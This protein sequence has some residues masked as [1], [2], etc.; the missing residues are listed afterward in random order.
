MAVLYVGLTIGLYLLFRELYR[1]VKHPLLS[2]VATSGLVL[3]LLLSNLDVP[4]S[5]YMAG[6]QWIDKLLGPAVVAFAYPMYY[7]RKLIRKNWVPLLGGVSMAVLVTFTVVFSWA[8][9]LGLQSKIFRTLLPE[10]VT[11]PIAMDLSRQLGG[12]PSL[13]AIMVVFAGMCGA[14][15][16]PLLY[17]WIRVDHPLGRGV[18][19]GSASHGV[20]TAQAME[21]G[22]IVGAIS[23]VSMTL[24]AMV[25]AGVSLWALEFV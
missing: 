9:F 13:T 19:F 1:R 24:T 14:V 21:E 2:P 3:I 11:T 6:G 16:G 15:L 20:G 17:R 8:N 10:S 23:T 5:T 7:H 25:T 22:E 12:I 4:Y 18:G